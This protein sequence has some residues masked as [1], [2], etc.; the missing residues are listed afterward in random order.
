MQMYIPAPV[1][2]SAIHP[3]QSKRDFTKNGCRS[4]CYCIFLLSLTSRPLPRFVE[5]K[6]E[7]KVGKK[8][9]K[10]VGKKVEKKVGKL[11]K[12]SRDLG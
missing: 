9:E 12:K 11:G 2:F 1:P 7:K 8:V 10:K 4:I 3:A 6:V 5:K